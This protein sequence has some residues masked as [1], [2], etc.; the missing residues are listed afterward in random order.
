MAVETLVAGAANLL[1]GVFLIP[2]IL[3]LVRTRD[4]AGVSST[5]AAFGALTNTTWVIYLAM[6]GLWAAAVAPALAVLAY[7]IMVRFL[8]RDDLRRSWIWLSVLYAF[9]F[10]VV[11][12]LG[13]T[14]ALAPMLAL[15]PVVQL[16]PGMTSVFRETHPTGVSPTTW[17]LSLCEAVLWG[18]YG[19][20][21]SDTALV[22]YGLFTGAGSILILGRLIATRP[23]LAYVALRL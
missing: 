3:R 9:L 2:Q 20:L 22:G 6:I 23:R 15:T 12:G 19:W 18:L 4:T 5:W 1:A 8:V 14:D 7:T 21:V 13:G 17:G 10:S 16:A 11:A